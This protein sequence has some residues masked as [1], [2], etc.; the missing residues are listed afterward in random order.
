MTTAFLALLILW[1]I[2]GLPIL[3]Y[4]LG[5][6]PNLS[7]YPPTLDPLPCINPVTV[8]L[9]GPTLFISDL[10]LTHNEDYSR[11]SNLPSFILARGIRNLVIVGDLFNSPS[12][13][14]KILGEVGDEAN[15]NKISHLLG[16]NGTIQHLYFVKSSRSHDPAEF[17]LTFRDEGFEFRTLGK[18]ARFTNNDTGVLTIHGDDAFGGLHGFIFSYLTGRPFL[19]GWWKDVIKIDDD[20]WVIMGHSHVPGI[21]YSRRV[22]NT[23]GWTDLLG[24]GPPRGSGILLLEEEVMLVNVKG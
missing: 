22:A 14:L 21:D 13:S 9:E 19:E 17:N 16:L 24:F 20:E 18:C 1:L 10:H 2:L 12:D 5:V 4:P 23:G 3:F 15:A 11:F 6:I 8:F 7:N